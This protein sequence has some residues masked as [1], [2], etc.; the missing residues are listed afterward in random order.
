MSRP[1]GLKQLCDN[2][3]SKTE[4]LLRMST[5][6]LLEELAEVETFGVCVFEEGKMHIGRS[7]RI[8][9]T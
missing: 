3:P 9:R 5:K 4:N 1:T 8:L 6:I 7:F 2:N